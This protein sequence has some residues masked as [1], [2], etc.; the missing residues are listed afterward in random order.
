MKILVTGDWHIDAVKIDKIDIDT[1]LDH[2]TR[3]FFNAIDKI[4]DHAINNNVDV[5]ILNGDLFK[6][7]SSTRLIETLVAE[8]FQKISSKMK[9]IINLGNHDIAP[10]Q[11]SYGVHT[12]S[13]IEKLNLPNTIINSE[14][15][16]LKL[17]NVDLILYPYYDL[18]RVKMKSNEELIDSIV[19]KV[20]SF[21]LQQPC[22]LFIGHGTPQGTIFH[23]DY[24]I[25][26]DS[27]SEPLLPLSMFENIDMALFSHIHRCHSINDKVFHIGSPERVDFSEAD[28]DKG[29]VIYDT[30]TKKIE[31]ISTN[32]RPMKE[33]KIDL[34]SISEFDDPN[35]LI[36]KELSFDNLDQ[37]MIK[38]SVDLT[39]QSYV[40]I[41]QQLIYQQLEKSFWFKPPIWN[42]PRNQQTRIKELTE[43]LNED[44]ALE[45]IL[46]L[47]D[48]LT[49]DDKRQILLRGKQ[50]LLKGSGTC[51]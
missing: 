16:H 25:D 34:M 31:W 22:K 8:R 44:Q 47:K 48:D 33:I 28:Q 36:L 39:E 5:F 1:D 13:I 21:D 35:E 20:E 27:V 7:R 42:K 50:I 30:D 12:Y 15:T 14:I 49:D 46:E 26:L 9:L 32:P 2:R 40:Q 4:I 3:D 17:D 51:D 10:R 23:E 38:I 6:G 37:T 41:N 18:K 11:L 19:E 45:K 43:Q 24:F 29:F